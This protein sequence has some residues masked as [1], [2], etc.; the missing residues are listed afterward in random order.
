MFFFKDKYLHTNCLAALANMSSKFNNLHPY[1]CQ[2]INSLFNLLA[3]KR[4]KIINSLNEESSKSNE[5]E[6]AEKQSNG[7]DLVKFLF[8]LFHILLFLF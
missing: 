7:Q 6:E 3:K 5:Q 4:T 2:R 8:K 1:V